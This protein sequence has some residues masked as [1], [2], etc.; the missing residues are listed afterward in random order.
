LVE[1]E[2]VSNRVCSVEMIGRAPCGRPI[3]TTLP[4]VDKDP[5]CLMHSHD[6]AKGDPL[7]RAE[8]QK[9]L[10]ATLQRSIMGIADFTGFVFFDC[11]FKARALSA[12]CCF[13]S[14]T[15]EQMAEFSGVTF[16][17]D[18]DFSHTKFRHHA[19]FF[20]TSFIGRADFFDAE[21]EQDA[22]FLRATFQREASFW[23][24]RFAASADFSHAKFLESAEFRYTAFCQREARFPGPIFS[25]TEFTRPEM[26]NFCK[27]DLSQA[28]FHDCDVTKVNF[29]SVIW[30]T[31]KGSSKRM[32]FEEIVELG[33]PYASSLWT[34]GED[35][36]E[37]DYVVIAELYQRLKKNYDERK[38]Y[39]TAGDFHYGEME[40]QRLALPAA[41]P[42]ARFLCWLLAGRF[43]VT[44]KGLEAFRR[45]WHQQ[46]SLVAWYKRASEY[47]ENYI[48][49]LNCLALTLLFFA[50]AF[51]LVG[52]QYDPAKDLTAGK[53]AKPEVLSYRNA[54]PGGKM[55]SDSYKSEYQ[56]VLDSGLSTV[57]IAFF[58]KNPIYEP[59]GRAGRVLSL[60]EMLVTSTLIALFLLAIR[61]QFRR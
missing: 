12:A 3:H 36:N 16:G 24:T 28:L 9:E 58:Q 61:R 21:F 32:A 53:D 46:L 37:R 41:G 40:M 17:M 23:A 52:L 57:E 18:A 48:R 10:D 34:E 2:H 33:T 4:T 25:F 43:G 27:A 38:D 47:G 45:W 54:S 19:Q 20:K 30:A 8:F 1:G 14:A 51:P 22:Y 59:A 49:P 13:S 11:N 35:P 29:S 7:L 60:V 56:L 15:F 5:V 50:L 6:L 31:R 55:A 44:Q 42:I 39:W 26:V